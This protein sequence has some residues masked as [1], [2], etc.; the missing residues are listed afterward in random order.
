MKTVF[1]S[2]KLY[3]AAESSS[4]RPAAAFSQLIG[5]VGQVL[6]WEVERG[7]EKSSQTAQGIG[8]FAPKQRYC[9]GYKTRKDGS[10]WDAAILLLTRWS[11]MVDKA[12]DGLHTHFG[13]VLFCI[14]PGSRL[15]STMTH[16]KL[17]MAPLPLLPWLANTMAPKR[18]IS[19]FPRP[20]SSSCCSP[21]TTVALQQASTSD[22][23]VR[24]SVRQ[25]CYD[26]DMLQYSQEIIL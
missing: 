4:G 18:L 26:G 13:L 12:W 22:T 10:Q 16:W 11:E 19:W 14:I 9:C 1:V 23:R 15:R 5:T 20:T 8:N 3:L 17:E 21:L 24:L 6:L 7:H 25:G 2:S